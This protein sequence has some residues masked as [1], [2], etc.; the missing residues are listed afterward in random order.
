MTDGYRQWSYPD[1]FSNPI[2][3]IIRKEL[4]REIKGLPLE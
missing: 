4:N 3:R 1:G 2:Y